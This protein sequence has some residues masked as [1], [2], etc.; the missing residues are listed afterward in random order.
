MPHRRI[1]VGL[2]A[3]A[4]VLAFGATIFSDHA[5]RSKST[6]TSPTRTCHI[7][8]PD[9]EVAIAAAIARCANGSVVRFPPGRRY[10]QSNRILIQDRRD[11]VIDGNGSTFTTDRVGKGPVNGNWVVLRGFNITL[12]N[13]T[14]VG[15]FT[16]SGERSLARISPDPSFSE[17]NS[18][19]GL[20]GVDT[21]HLTDVKAYGPWGDGVTTGP[22]EYIDGSNPEYSRNVFIKRMQVEKTARMCWGPT[23]GM[24][25]WIEDSSCKDA[26]YGGLDAEIDNPNQP[27]QG[28]H[29]LRNTF[30]GFNQLGIFIPVAAA[31]VPTRDI[32]I[33]GNKFLTPPD[34]KCSAP[35][36][37]GGYPDSNPAMFRDVIISGNYLE[38]YGSG[39]VQDH[40]DGGS[41]EGNTLAPLSFQGLTPE[42]LCGA[43]FHDPIRVTNSVNVAVGRNAGQ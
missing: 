24:N 13:M 34:Q 6:V 1:L 37:V 17:A 7:D 16:Y 33:R 15:T 9:G 18:N 19:Y 5:R 8:P 35:I 10:H 41:I 4:L 3:A 43:G 29:V 20:Y 27:L 42:G 36:H 39:I 31:N 26:W 12:K 25:V 22:D 30:D 21:V 2:L 11:L 38:H 40:V 14:S 28:V 23:S 32:E